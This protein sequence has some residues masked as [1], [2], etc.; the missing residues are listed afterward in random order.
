MEYYIISLPKKNS[1]GE[2]CDAC[3]HEHG[4]VGPLS[5]LVL[6]WRPNN[7]G[8]TVF[9]ESAGRYSAELVE[10][11]ASYYNNGETTVAVACEIVD[12]FAKRAVYIDHLYAL[13]KLVPP[14]TAAGQARG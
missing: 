4:I 8:Y 1:S 2:Q 14:M 12:R 9:L 10:T 13:R 6:F 5:D 3:G 7:S 11:K